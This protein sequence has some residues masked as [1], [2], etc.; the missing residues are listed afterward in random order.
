MNFSPKELYVRYIKSHPESVVSWGTFLALRP[1]YVRTATAKDLEVC[2]CKVHL[3]AR[4]WVNT[5]IKSCKKQNIDID[6]ING[7]S[8]FLIL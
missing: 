8:S 6:Q 7:Y 1:F 2:C 3:H 4:W 5:L